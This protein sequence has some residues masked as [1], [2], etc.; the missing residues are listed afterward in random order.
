METNASVITWFNNIQN[1]S[2]F[3]FLKFDIV[4]FNPSISKELLNMTYAL[5][6]HNGSI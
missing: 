5:R 3:K 1:K 2:Q 6:S 4:N